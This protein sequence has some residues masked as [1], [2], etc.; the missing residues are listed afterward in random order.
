M[1]SFL[2][3]L[4]QLQKQK[5]VPRNDG[6]LEKRLGTTRPQKLFPLS[7]LVGGLFYMFLF[8]YSLE[9]SKIISETNIVT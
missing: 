1:F 3:S 8:I 4:S 2:V 5:S 9:V 6:H 7:L